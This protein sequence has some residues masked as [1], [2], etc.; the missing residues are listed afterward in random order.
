MKADLDALLRLAAWL[1]RALLVLAVLGTVIAY[2][3]PA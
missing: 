3:R 2:Q 1:L